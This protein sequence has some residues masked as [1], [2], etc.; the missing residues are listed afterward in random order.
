MRYVGNVYIKCSAHDTLQGGI[1]HHK[2][3]QHVDLFQINETRKK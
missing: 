3:N 2:P 1:K